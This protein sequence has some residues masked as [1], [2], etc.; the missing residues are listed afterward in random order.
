M[1]NML[2]KISPPHTTKGLPTSISHVEVII[3]E[4][5][6]FYIYFNHILVILAFFF[7]VSNP[8]DHGI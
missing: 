6:Y 4:K 5:K 7:S 3:H 1:V 8:K 2:S